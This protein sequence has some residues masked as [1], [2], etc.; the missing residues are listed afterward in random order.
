MT[1]QKQQDIEE[2]KGAL[3]D[4]WRVEMVGGVT[5]AR[6]GLWS[7]WASGYIYALSVNGLIS[8][9]VEKQALDFILW[10]SRR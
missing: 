9:E 6:K 5:A 2:V 4:A 3:I 7:S 10:K 1:R 8:L